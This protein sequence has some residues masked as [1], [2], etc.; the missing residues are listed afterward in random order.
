MN[1]DTRAH[2]EYWRPNRSLAR[3]LRTHPALFDCQVATKARSSHQDNTKN[4]VELVPQP[5][6]VVINLLSPGRML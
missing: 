4:Y 2:A 1:D 6:K 3:S 5:T